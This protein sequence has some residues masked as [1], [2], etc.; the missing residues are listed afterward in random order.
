[1]NKQRYLVT[2]PF[3]LEYNT[4]TKSQVCSERML[5]MEEILVLDNESSNGNVW[6]I[7]K[8]EARGKIQCGCV[9]NLVNRGAVKPLELLS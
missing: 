9:K 6:F 7:D 1:M 3:R 4:H 2:S 8:N 5:D